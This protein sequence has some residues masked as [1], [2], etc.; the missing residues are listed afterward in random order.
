[1]YV[2][3][4][5]CGVTFIGLVSTTPS[6]V[7]SIMPPN[8]PACVLGG[9]FV[10]P[11]FEPCAP[12]TTVKARV[13]AT[14][15][16]TVF[17]A[18]F[19]YGRRPVLALNDGSAIVATGLGG[20][21]RINQQNRATVLWRPSQSD[22]Y[23]YGHPI[24][25]L[26]LFSGGAVVYAVK[27]VLGVR[28]DG[29]VAFRKDVYAGNVSSGGQSI[30]AAQDREGTVW[31]AD[32]SGP[33]QAMYA[34]VP[35]THRV[36]DI[37]S[38][39]GK[40]IRA[41]N[42][43]VYESGRDGLFELDVQPRFSR[44]F[45]HA[46]IRVPTPR[47]GQLDGSPFA[48]IQAVGS[49]GSLWGATWTQV[50]HVHPDGSMRVIRLA[51]PLTSIKMPPTNIN[52][53][54]ARDGSVWTTSKLVR[55]VSDDRVEAIDLAGNDGWRRGPSF[56]PDNTGWTILSGENGGDASVAHFSIAP[57]RQQPFVATNKAL[58]VATSSPPPAPPATP[59]PPLPP[60]SRGV[61]FVYLAN[62]DPSSVS[63]Y[64]AERR[65]KLIPVRGSPFLTGISLESVTVDPTGRFLYAGG[66]SDGIAA[67]AIDAETGALHAIAGSP[68]AAGRGPTSIAIDRIGRYAYANN[69]NSQTITVYSIDAHS[70]AL[71]PVAGSPYAMGRV[72]YR[73]VLNP[74]GHFAYVIFDASIETFDTG[75]GTFRRVAETPLLNGRSGGS[76]I[77]VDRYGRRAYV[78][79]DSTNTISTYAV[80]ERNGVLHPTPG[81]PRNAGLGPRDIR[82]DPSDRFVYVAN[83]E[84]SPSISVY[85]VGE[86]TGRLTAIPGSPFRGSDSPQAMTITPD[87]VFLYAT[88]F[89]SKS[90]AGFAVNERTGA[91]NVLVGSPFKA[92]NRPWGITSC[93]RVSNRC[94]PLRV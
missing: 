9:F 77:V 22:D 61:D 16:T 29:S 4:A 27:S 69:I 8:R 76:N 71:A 58:R 63:A 1:M 92:G 24:E 74:M 7:P 42:G 44:R 85:Q 91:L 79:N 25:L 49:D 43:R 28:N 23:W 68:F 2:R 41:P 54:M 82:I 53:T 84:K 59:S 87:G 90:V 20:L 64:W 40:I 14:F 89:D 46:V 81:P 11:D 34:Y 70:G 12:F 60:S 36:V 55:I 78:T 18:S 37:P 73:L 30:T 3:V 45:V 19:G 56:G 32:N 75:G 93:R 50:I 26:A 57:S 17:G 6:P 31:I 88:N 33:K 15:S 65:G 13:I 21:F 5:I 48:D 67:Y 62:G 52:L 94:K 35:R 47:P 39:V 38:G 66:W 80:D 72:P 83:I 86:Q 51:P 10:R